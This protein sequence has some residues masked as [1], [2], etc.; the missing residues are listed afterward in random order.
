MRGGL[1][2]RAIEQL[3][4][5]HLDGRDLAG[6]GH[7]LI[8]MAEDVPDALAANSWACRFTRRD[9]HGLVCTADVSGTPAPT[10]GT[11]SCMG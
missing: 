4:G 8:L 11:S 3:E 5:V 6:L 10:S 1:A 9:G 2:R 7:E